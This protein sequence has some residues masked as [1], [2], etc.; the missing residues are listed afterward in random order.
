VKSRSLR[1]A[2]NVEDIWNAHRMKPLGKLP[3]GRPSQW[4]ITLKWLSQ[5]YDMNQ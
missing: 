5:R 1:G 3:L 2:G 4:R